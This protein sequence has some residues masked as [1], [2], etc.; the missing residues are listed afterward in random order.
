MDLLQLKNMPWHLRP[1]ASSGVR[2][3]R[4]PGSLSAGCRLTVPARAS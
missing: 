3:S 4:G 1:P 2:V